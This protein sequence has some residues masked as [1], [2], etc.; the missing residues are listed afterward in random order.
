MLL[1]ILQLWR[2]G[3][4]NYKFWKSKGPPQTLMW[5]RFI[6]QPITNQI[7]TSSNN[8]RHWWLAQTC[9]V[10]NNLFHMLMLDDLRES[11]GR[12]KGRVPCKN[13]NLFFFVCVLWMFFLFFWLPVSKSLCR[14]VFCCSR[15]WGILVE[16]RRES[17]GRKKGRVPC[18]NCNLFF[19]VCVLWMFF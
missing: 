19:F 3:W 16:R 14:F 1:G 9:C 11:R 4:F 7:S 8:C 17:R 13:C 6:I 10:C 18:G 12:K 15:L 2:H 5:T